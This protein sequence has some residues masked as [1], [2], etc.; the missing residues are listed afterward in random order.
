MRGILLQGTVISPLNSAKKVHK[1]R[2]TITQQK[3]K[4]E[5]LLGS[6]T[7]IVF[8]KIALFFEYLEQHLRRHE[9]LCFNYS[10]YFI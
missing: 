3:K 1:I 8:F 6:V 2:E 4:K 7:L 10:K 5:G 9:L